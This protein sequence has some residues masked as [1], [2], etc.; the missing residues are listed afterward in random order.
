MINW[1]YILFWVI[2]SFLSSF[3]CVLDNDWRIFVEGDWIKEILTPILVWIIA[4]FGDYLYT[5]CSIDRKRQIENTFYTK[6][7]YILVEV[8]FIT[9][10]L[11]CHLTENFGRIICL[12]ILYLCMIGLK[13]TSLFV[14]CPRQKVVKI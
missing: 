2:I 7:S 12:I 5:I 4:F 13:A 1:I 8:I 3:I 10:L 6:M 14:I 9:I 11:G